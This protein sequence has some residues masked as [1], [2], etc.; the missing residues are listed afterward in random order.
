MAGLT[1]KYWFERFARLP[2]DDRGRLR[3]PLRRGADDAGR[4]DDRRLAVGRDGRYA[5]L[6]ALRQG[7]RA[8]DHRRRQRPTSTMARESDV[9][10][11]DPRRPGDRRRLDQGLH[12][13][14]RRAR[15]PGAGDRPGAG[16]ARRRRRG[17]A[18]RRSHRRAGPDG[19]TRSSRKGSVEHL[20]RDARQ[21]ARRA[22]PRPRHLVSR[23]R[24]R[25]R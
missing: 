24:W 7:E 23:S 1:A 22:L 20:A 16:H 17:A 12:L 13:P 4:P 5:G 6:A 15:L 10:C 8:E 21:G 11:A 19:R 14:A 25:A 3:V 18:R 2:V 9:A